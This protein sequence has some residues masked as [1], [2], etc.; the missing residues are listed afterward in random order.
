MT[1]VNKTMNAILTHIFLRLFG[2][3]IGRTYRNSPDNAC[4]DAI[5]L[6]GVVLAVPL[7]LLICAFEI[8]L[9][10]LGEYFT[11]GRLF[12][13]AFILECSPNVGPRVC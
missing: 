4:D 3:T 5:T 11:S 10:G 13:V 12:A 2:F 8:L 7:G 6:L 9:P 1:I